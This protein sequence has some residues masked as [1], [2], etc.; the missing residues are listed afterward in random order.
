MT[1]DSSEE[2]KPIGK[3]IGSAKIVAVGEGAH[4]AADNPRALL[5]SYRCHCRFPEAD[6][7]NVIDSRI[8]V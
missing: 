3:M 2:L 6:V 5:A 1:G 8:M 4:G 7:S